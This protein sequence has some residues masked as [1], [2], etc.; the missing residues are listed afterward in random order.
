MFNMILYLYVLQY[1]HPE[2]LKMLFPVV[3]TCK[4]YSLS[5]FQIYSIVILTIVAMLHRSYFLPEFCALE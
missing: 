3:R 1:D 4:I 2:K 5:N